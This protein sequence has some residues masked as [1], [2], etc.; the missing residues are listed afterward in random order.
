MAKATQVTKLN[1][2]KYIA[3]DPSKCTGCGLCEYVCALEKSEGTWNL[4]MSR[5][6][7][8]RMHPLLNVAIACKFCKDA[9]CLTA[10]PEKALK[11]SEESSVLT[12]DENK[13]K[14]C[15]WCIQACPHGG[16]TLHPDKTL[17]I[18][19]DLCGGEPKCIDSC[20]EKALELVSDDKEFENKWEIAI[21]KLPHEIERLA[22]IVKKREWSYLL[23]EA[24]ERAVKTSE[25][26]E[27]ISKR[28]HS[29]RKTLQ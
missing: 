2:R 17:V 11:Q 1:S 21:Q 23:A 8:V 22:E 14:G 7:V 19:C 27:K 24:K 4:L 28:E 15:D 5:I 16:L 12:V 13:C 29:N 10:C 26:L 25:K 18:A 9:R 6:R 20:P 3:A